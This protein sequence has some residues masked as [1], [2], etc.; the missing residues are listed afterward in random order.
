[1]MRKLGVSAGKILCG[2]ALLL[3]LSGCFYSKRSLMDDSL[4][5]IP[6]ANGTYCKYRQDSDR[7]EWQK[8]C[9]R[10]RLERQGNTAMLYEDDKTTEIKAYSGPVI[11]GMFKGYR[12][13]EACEVPGEK[14]ENNCQFVVFKMI[15]GDVHVRVPSCTSSEG[16]SCVKTRFSEIVQGIESTTSQHR[17]EA[18]KYVKS[19]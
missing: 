7:L 9:E 15:D 18:L 5:S 4:S 16:E 14:D 8:T 12:I 6:F 11:S 10:V 17:G 3:V 19:S 1:M 2:G 13:I